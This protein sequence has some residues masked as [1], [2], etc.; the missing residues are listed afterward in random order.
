MTESIELSARARELLHAI[1]TKVVN[2]WDHRP[3]KGGS[4]PDRETMNIRL[5]ARGMSTQKKKL[6][7]DGFDS[8]DRGEI[9]AICDA[10]D[11]YREAG[12]TVNLSRRQRC[13]S[14]VTVHMTAVEAARAHLENACDNGRSLAER[15]QALIAESDP[16]SWPNRWAQKSLQYLEQTC[17]DSL[18]RNTYGGA[19]LA[20]ADIV[21]AYN[22]SDK[23]ITIRELSAHALRDSKMLERLYTTYLINAAM[24]GGFVF[25]EQ[26]KEDRLRELGIESR[27]APRYV[28]IGGNVDLN[29]GESRLP[30]SFFGS[31]GL[32]I[33]ESSI[34]GL[35]CDGVDGVLVI[36]NRTNFNAVAGMGI[37]GLLCVFSDGYVN[38][39][40]VALLK[41]LAYLLPDA[42]P[43]LVWSDI[44]EGGFLIASKLM[45]R[46]KR[47][48]PLLM[49]TR[50]L[51]R[52]RHLIRTMTP[53]C[54][55]RLKT[56]LKTHEGSPL[57]DTVAWCLDNHGTLEQ[58]CML[59][60]YAQ[61]RISDFFG[62]PSLDEASNL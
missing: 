41:R 54:A 46:V 33:P 4:I 53:E 31:D 57:A 23:P 16:G 50:D 5:A 19:D 7:I 1:D 25:K 18:P 40:T 37:P 20:V 11:L 26:K 13:P 28:C 59:D 34:S 55:Q 17:E 44:D 42:V 52:Y 43:M 56:F 24:K 39:E 60:G 10:L 45:K 48:R 9:D 30:L 27:I 15:L 58:E 35:G 51:E 49:G 32:Q 21:A 38:P 6:G 8:R 62:V 3:E 29:V 36:E 61:H 47:F 12:C 22:A 14:S 2:L